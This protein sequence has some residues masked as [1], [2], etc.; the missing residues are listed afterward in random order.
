M[1]D[2]EA[3][4]EFEELMIDVDITKKDK[5]PVV[6]ISSYEQ[7]K[8]NLKYLQD[9]EQQKVTFLGIEQRQANFRILDDYGLVLALQSNLQEA[10]SRYI[11]RK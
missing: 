9:T 10:F 6:K 3:I 7:L 4:D 1:P 11:A 2:F 8:S 5:P